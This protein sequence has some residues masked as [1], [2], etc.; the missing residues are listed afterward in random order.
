MYNQRHALLATSNGARE[1]NVEEGA[2]QEFWAEPRSP[3][4]DCRL[5]RGLDAAREWQ[6]LLLFLEPQLWLLFSGC[7]AD[8]LPELSESLKL[9]QTACGLIPHDCV[10]FD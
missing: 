5:E 10:L 6:C 2:K 7:S 8:L 4:P 3:T 1:G 9:R